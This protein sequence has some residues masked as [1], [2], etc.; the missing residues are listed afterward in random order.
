MAEHF[1]TNLHDGLSSTEAAARLSRD[2][3]NSI[4]G[5]KGISFW[6]ILF[7]QVANA[8]TVVL[9]AV[10]ALSFAIGDYIE[11][12]V[13]LAVIVLNIVVGYVKMCKPHIPPSICRP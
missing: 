7:S 9:I 3:P 13:V 1:N 2:G 5:A 12:G 10:A 4:K 6:Q 8:L 11:G